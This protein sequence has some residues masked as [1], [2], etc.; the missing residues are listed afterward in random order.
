MC[1]ITTESL[2]IAAYLQEVAG[3]ALPSEACMHTKLGDLD[4]ELG[5]SEY[6]IGY[7][8]QSVAVLEQQHT[9]ANVRQE[10]TCLIRSV[11]YSVVERSVSSLDFCV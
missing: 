1:R 4:N 11:C 2:L 10:D 6:D 5:C 8:L 9:R 3:Y 7:N